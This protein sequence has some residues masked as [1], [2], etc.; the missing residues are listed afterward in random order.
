MTWQGSAQR[1]I[2]QLTS[3][4]RIVG[5]YK[6]QRVDHLCPPVWNKRWLYASVAFEGAFEIGQTL[7]ACSIWARNMDFRVTELGHSIWQV[8]LWKGTSNILIICSK[9]IRKPKV[10]RTTLKMVKDERGSTLKRK[11]KLFNGTF[12]LSTVRQSKLCQGIIIIFTMKYYCFQ[13]LNIAS[14]M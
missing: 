8:L 1:S 5:Y 6:M 2:K 13:T 12:G 10:S 14:I 9:A 7:A 11:S 3:A 4:Y